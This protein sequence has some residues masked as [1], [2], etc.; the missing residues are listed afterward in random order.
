MTTKQELIKKKICQKKKKEK[1]YEKKMLHITWK[2]L[3]RTFIRILF[4]CSKKNHIQKHIYTQQ[5]QTFI[6]I[7]LYEI[8]CVSTEE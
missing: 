7:Y 2:S 5:A 8:T 4:L 3:N 1:T 6:C